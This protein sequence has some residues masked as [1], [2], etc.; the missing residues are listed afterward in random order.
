[1]TRWMPMVPGAGV[2][3]GHQSVMH[4]IPQ[5]LFLRS[6]D[7]T[8]RLGPLYRTVPYRVSASQTVQTWPLTIAARRDV[9]GLPT[10]SSATYIRSIVYAKPW[11]PIYLPMPH[12]TNHTRVGTSRA[13][14][15]MR[16]LRMLGA[17]DGRMA[18]R[19]MR[20]WMDPMAMIM[21]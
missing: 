10:P 3:V 21:R 11:T 16:Y 6:R 4:A 17:S 14:G 18:S 13:V 5:S 20:Y 1:M 12:K 2:L 9:S 8:L 15:T 19:L 7:E